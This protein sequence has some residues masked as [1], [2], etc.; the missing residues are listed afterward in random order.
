MDRS[1]P[2]ISTVQFLQRIMWN[3][4]RTDRVRVE[5]FP[6]LTS[7][8]IFRRTQKNLQ[9]QRIDSEH[10]EG[11]IIFMSMFNDV[12][13]TKKENSET[14]I[15]NSEQVKNYAKRFPRG[16]WSFLSPGDEEK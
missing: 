5:N 10:F 6:G 7:L 12:G 4:W 1:T 16:R 11:R 14:G 3:R 2:R 13:W 8:E 15:S 9:D